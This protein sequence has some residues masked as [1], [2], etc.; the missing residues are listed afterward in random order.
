M[1]QTSD[2]AAITKELTS[3]T[4]YKEI[5][6]GSETLSRYAVA[7]WPGTDKQT[8]QRLYWVGIKMYASPFWEFIDNNLTDDRP[9][10]NDWK[11]LVAPVCRD[12]S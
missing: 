2:V 6:G 5:F 4:T 1:Y 10:R 7:I 12:A 9:Y 3:I 8:G 11:H